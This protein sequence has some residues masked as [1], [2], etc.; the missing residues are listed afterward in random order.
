MWKVSGALYLPRG[1]SE[2]STRKSCF[3]AELDKEFAPDL[4]TGSLHTFFV[5]TPWPDLGWFPGSREA[6]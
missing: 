6:P 4:P 5:E 2:S 3:P 1:D